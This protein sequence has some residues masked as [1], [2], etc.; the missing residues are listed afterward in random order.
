MSPLN[1]IGGGVQPQPRFGGVFH[2]WGCPYMD[3]SSV[4]SN[5]FFGERFD[6]TRKFQGVGSSRKCR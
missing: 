2:C 1:M 5:P 4:A 6:C 3:S